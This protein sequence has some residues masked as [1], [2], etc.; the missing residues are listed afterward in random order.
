[1][2][3]KTLMTDF[4]ELTMAQTYFDE[5]KKDEEIYFDIFFRSNPFN[6]GY[7]ISGGLDNI[8]EYIENFKIGD[9]EINYL[10]SLGKFSEEFLN[11][12]K[13][14][15]F[16]G[17]VY[18]IPDG[19]PIFPNEPV[20][21]VK[22][23]TVEAQILETA[24][25][26]HFNHGSL[27]TTASKRITNEAGNIPV[28][29]FGARRARGLDSAI[30]ASKYSYVG[31]CAGTSNTYT[32]MKYNIPVLGTMAHS[33]VTE[34]ETEYE[35]FL[36]Y[37]KSNPDNC[38]FLVDTY[39]TLK[40]GIPNAIRVAQDY[41]IPNGYKFKG[42]RIDSGDLAYLS[43]EA[44]KLLDEYG[45]NDTAICLSNGLNEYTIRDLLNQGAVIDSLG[46]GDNIS[47]S[48][49]RVGGVYKL[50]A[51]DVN[52]LAD[53]RIKVSNDTIKTINPGYKKVYRFYDKDTGYALGDVIT[54]A[55]ECVPKD[56][57]TLIHPIDNWK[58]TTIRNYNIREL[59]VPIYQN[60]E[61][62]YNMP[63]VHL[64]KE[65][66]KKEF[67]T[68]YPEIK[69]LINPHEY[70]VDLSLKLL[71]LK[72]QLI[73]EHRIEILDKGPVKKLVR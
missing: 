10:R 23:K 36:G 8:I 26:T 14:I 48:K 31:G 7:T 1:M 52:G 33:L 5:G 12:L 60:G 16:T 61:L 15:K 38:V 18:A 65:Y 17:D 72:Q 58:K 34:S 41:L 44:R 24:L 55:D 45:F 54:L 37:A 25:L 73:E 29:E 62:V 35:A 6:G 30:E 53:P 4:Y 66:C 51:V 3:N 68:L 50:V 39:N 40:S 19:T 46:V 71:K 28:M 47:A 20:I 27:V 57:Y 2:A 11:Y 22:A 64:R 13:D 59:Q 32:G 56:E 69:R 42:I 21:T 67:D 49:D 70:Y 9:Q 43:K 63:N